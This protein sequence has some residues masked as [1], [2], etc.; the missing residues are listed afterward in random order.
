MTGFDSRKKA[1]EAKLTHEGELNFKIDARRR[2]LLGV[3]AGEQMGKNEETSL[4][5]AL[6]IVKYGI[7]DKEPKAV[8]NKIIE[9]AKARDAEISLEDL[10]QKNREFAEIARKQITAP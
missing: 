9:D 1:E 5:Y 7:Q 2:K 4:E 6:E 8:M 3:W 10:E